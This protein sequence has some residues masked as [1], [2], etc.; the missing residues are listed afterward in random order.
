MQSIQRGVALYPVGLA[1]AREAL[2]DNTDN[3]LEQVPMANFKR[4]ATTQYYGA[5]VNC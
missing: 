3:P 4:V 1:V 5:Y 2:V